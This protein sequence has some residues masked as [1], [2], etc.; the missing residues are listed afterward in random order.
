MAVYMCKYCGAIVEKSSTPSNAGCP[1]HN[2]HGWHKVCHNGSIEPKNG[3]NAYSCK[4]CGKIVYCSSTP[5][6]VGCP[7]HNS[8]SWHKL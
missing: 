3:F 7:A 5:A 2:T 6:G 4:Y 8:H 1:V